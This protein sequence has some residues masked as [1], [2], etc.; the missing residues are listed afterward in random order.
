MLLPIHAP[1]SS[2]G[3]KSTMNPIIQTIV[4]LNALP[5]HFSACRD[6]LQLQISPI[7]HSFNHHRTII[8]AIC[9]SITF[10]STLFITFYQ[11]YTFISYKMP[12]KA[13]KVEP[14]NPNYWETVSPPVDQDLWKQYMNEEHSNT[15]IS[16]SEDEE[17][18]AGPSN[19]V[20][21]TK[22]DASDAD[23]KSKFD[24]VSHSEPCLRYTSVNSASESLTTDRSC[25][26]RKFWTTHSTI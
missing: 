21:G 26:S 1:S 3:V 13:L 23:L 20:D 10:L 22:K 15:D 5:I 25:R 16:D 18:M 24:L 11:F 4:A 6:I 12:S 2:H 14:L 8:R 19:T 7:F 17:L 9:W